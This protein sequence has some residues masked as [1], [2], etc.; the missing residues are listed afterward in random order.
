MKQFGKRIW[1]G[2]LA[3]AGLLAGSGGVLSGPSVASLNV[4]TDQ[5]VML[6]A[7]PGQ[8][9]SVSNLARD[10]TLSSLHVEARQYPVNKGVAE[11]VL[12]VKP[13]LVVTGTFSLHNTT[14]LLS[15]LGFAV[16]EFE[17]SQSVETIATDIRRMGRLLEQSARAEV[18]A[19]RFEHDL[20]ALEP[21][22]CS[23]KP[24]ALF[25]GARGVALGKGTLAHSA[26]QAAGFINMAAERGYE[27]VAAF[28][29]E[30]LVQ[31]PPD[32]IILPKS[33][34]GAPALAD[35]ILSH[36]VLRKLKTTVTG[37]FSRPASLNCG[38]PFTM[39]AIHELRALA[40]SLLPCRKAPG[41]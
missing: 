20:A 14:G 12:L 37:S 29:L 25:Y 15:R 28:P 6:L 8:L 10:P 35:E 4:C 36:P 11:E 30:L 18:M 16:E 41:S 3:A 23:R 40:P 34:P 21:L 33:T 9:K 22:A 17:Y 19:S 2:A 26:M 38:G 5:L 32:L 31:D 13:D 1:T 7:E 39:Q 24:V 27:G